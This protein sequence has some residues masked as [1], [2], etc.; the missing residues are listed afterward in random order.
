[1]HKQGKYVHSSDDGGDEN[2][3]RTANERGV[4]T[5]EG[6]K[7]KQGYTQNVCVGVPETVTA[8]E[9]MFSE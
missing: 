8:T 2:A 6:S 5:F 4:N 7:G 1:M 9:W 3:E